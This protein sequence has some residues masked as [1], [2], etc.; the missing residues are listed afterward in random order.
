MPLASQLLRERRKLTLM[1]KPVLMLMPGDGDVTLLA[2]QL[3]R[4]RPR[5]MLTLKP[6]LGDGDTMPLA[7]QLLN[8]PTNQLL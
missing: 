2:N 7:S 5:P 1:L 8:C 3:L 6:M 4:E